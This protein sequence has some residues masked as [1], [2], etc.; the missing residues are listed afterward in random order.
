L[1]LH[2]ALLW[3]FYSTCRAVCAAKLFFK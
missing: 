1:H 3:R 2:D